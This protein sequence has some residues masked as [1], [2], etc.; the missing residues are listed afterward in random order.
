MTYDLA[1]VNRNS[2]R[3]RLTVPAG[4]LRWAGIPGGLITVS[5]SLVNGGSENA[6]P[7]AV[8]SQGLRRLFLR[9][10]SRHFRRRFFWLHWIQRTTARLDVIHKRFG[11]RD[12]SVDEYFLFWKPIDQQLLPLPRTVVSIEQDLLLW[13]L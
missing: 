1:T 7:R 5:S 8:R 6:G 12:I 3:S 11:D 9:D 10:V 13:L 2:L 4:V